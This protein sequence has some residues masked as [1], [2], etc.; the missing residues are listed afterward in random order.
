MVEGQVVFDEFNLN[1]EIIFFCVD[2]KYV[3]T[4]RECWNSFSFPVAGETCQTQALL[5]V[6]SQNDR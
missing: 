1:L 3:H 4:L 6:R 2:S 5:K